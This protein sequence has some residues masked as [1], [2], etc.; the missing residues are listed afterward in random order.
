MK[1]KTIRNVMPKPKFRQE[2][3]VKQPSM[4]VRF[5]KFLAKN[6]KRYLP[7]VL[8]FFVLGMI[9]VGWSTYHDWKQKS[10]MELFR[11]AKSEADY[12]TI[13]QKYPSTFAAG[14]SMIELGE[15]QWNQGQYAKARENYEFF[16]SRF[17]KSL[18]AP[19]IRNLIGECLFQEKKYDE[20]QKIFSSLLQDK[21]ENFI[22]T[23]AKMNLGRVLVAKGQLKEGELIFNELKRQKISG[24]WA[25]SID[26]FIRVYFRNN[27]K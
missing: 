10:G 20:A 9:Y 23:I 12:Q 3:P 7:Y 16:L 2:L 26:A 5:S 15:I 6:Q 25:D 8:V 11:T 17:P 13:V 21:E 19:F 4:T 18:F 27:Q 24:L 14:L 22:E 1:N